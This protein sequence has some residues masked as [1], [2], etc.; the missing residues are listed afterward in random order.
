[1]PTTGFHSKWINI[2]GCKNEHRIL[3]ECRSGFPSDEEEFIARV[4]VEL[5]DR[6]SDGNARVVRVFYNDKACIHDV[7]IASTD[8]KDSHL[9]NK[10]LNVLHSIFGNGNPTVIFIEVQPGNTSSDHYNHMEHLS[11]GAEVAA[12]RWKHSDPEYQSTVSSPS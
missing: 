8:K 1:M 10:L 5:V 2:K 6:N 9:E 11:V 7:I 12:D 4:A 3:L